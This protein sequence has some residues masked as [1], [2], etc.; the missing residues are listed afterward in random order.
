MQEQLI[1]LGDYPCINAY[2]MAECY[3]VPGGRV[4]FVMYDW[5]RMDGLWRRTITG[6]LTRPL[7]GLQEDQAVSWQEIAGDSRCAAL[8]TALQLSH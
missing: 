4:R 5:V 6:L 3:L 8:G 2:G 7:T 1:D